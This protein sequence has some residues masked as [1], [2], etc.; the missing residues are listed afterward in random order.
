MVHEYN[1]SGMTCS[2]CVSKIKSALLSMPSIDALELTLETGIA[3][4][5]MNEHI[6]LEQLQQRVAS[7]GNYT[8]SPTSREV[9]SIAH[10][11]WWQ[12]YAPVL[13]IFGYLIVSTTLI[14]VN[15][16]TFDIM[17]WMRHFMGGFFLAF[18]FFKMLNLPA[19]A[20][21][22]SSYDI[23]AKRWFGWGYVYAFAE[24]LLGLAYLTGVAPITTMVLTFLIMTISIIGVLQSVLSNKKIQCACLGTVFNLPMSTVTIIEDG[25][26]IAM[27]AAMLYFQL[28]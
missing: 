3:R 1:I 27:S 5:T 6:S 26:M 14:Q 9:E 24:L 13:L 15:S 4:I 22:Y 19:F 8:L 7:L 11:S 17:D 23:I 20:S 16:S 28:G 21:A 12:T 18:S 25:L 10:R 2:G